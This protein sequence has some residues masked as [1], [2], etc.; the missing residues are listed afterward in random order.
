M[1]F[2][3]MNWSIVFSP[4]LAPEF[5]VAIAI[6]GALLVGVALWRRQ[7]GALLRAAVFGM[8]IVALSGPGLVRENRE[9]LDDIVVVIADRSASQNLGQRRARTDAALTRIKA[10][11]DALPGVEM[12]VREVA[13]SPQGETRLMQALSTELDAIAPGRFAGAF[14][15][16]DG[17]VHDAADGVDGLSDTAPVH[18]L[19]TG[20]RGEY[21]RKLTLVNAPR[22]GIVDETRTVTF[23]VE[24]TAN[25]G[26]PPS[27][28]AEITIKI[29]GD[30]VATGR[31]E[32][33]KDVSMNYPIRHG[34]ASVIEIS[35]SALPGELTQG[36]NRASFTTNGIRDRLRVLL[37]SGEPHAG[38]RTWR[39]LLKADSAV[40]LVHFTILRPPDKQD[41]TPINELSLIAFPT[42]ELFAVKLR[43]FDL[44]IF[45]RY[46]RRGVLPMIYL[47]NLVDYVRRGGALLAATVPAY[48][49][50]RSIFRS[51]LASILPGTPTGNITEQPFRPKVT[52]LGLRHPVS[53]GLA[54]A[55]IKA[56]DVATWG[57]WF[58][59]IDAEISG[60]QTLMTGPD[61]KPL[62]ALERVGE[63][64]VALL[65]SDQA[66]LWARGFEGGGPQAELLRRL[67]HWLMKEPELEEEALKADY[68]GGRL[69]VTRR[70]LKDQ[71]GPVT[72]V[73]PSGAE[74]K[75]SLTQRKPGTWEGDVAVTEPGYY[76]IRDGSLRTM[77]VAGAT[78]SKEF[79]DVISTPERLAPLVQ[80]TGAGTAWLAGNAAGADAG[81]AIELPRLVRVR[82]GRA[83][84]GQG[85][86]GIRRREA[87]VARGSVYTALLAGP[88]AVGLMLGLLGLMWYRE[89]R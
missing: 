50:P 61:D 21:D 48:A 23:R 37:I 60:G 41:G 15:I 5:L 77:A 25:A 45:D 69:F 24:D 38:E 67:A 31:V 73:S 88:L 52:E 78:N 51:P 34:G 66:W 64:R 14:L 18:V 36:N 58:R 79:A 43:E 40:D 81:A 57:R 65:L 30:V 29:D 7:R 63:G 76:Q 53:A 84:Q 9:P 17:Q 35:V 4:W 11:I 54:G 19:L 33:G 62:L 13:G 80:K 56:S 75:L 55:N 85:W 72:I 6:A 26:K 1:T 44:V 3:D 42:R 70:T 83:A 22:Y 28:P 46:Q 49:G 82:A 59:L 74:S 8:L 20:T 47:D 87:Y 89:G 86:M 12:R 10:R 2:N 27:A 68:R 71:S 16:T 39:N 32:V